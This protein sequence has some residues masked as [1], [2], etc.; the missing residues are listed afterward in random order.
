MA[1]ALRWAPGL[2]VRRVSTTP[3]G[4]R[5][6][7]GLEPLRSSWPVGVLGLQ[8]IPKGKTKAREG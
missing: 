8:S 1:P 5:V 2:G 6:G 4:A 7:Q 3:R